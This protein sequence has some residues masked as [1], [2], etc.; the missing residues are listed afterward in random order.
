MGNFQIG[1]YICKKWEK[2]RG[3]LW[4]AES[5]GWWESQEGFRQDV[6]QWSQILDVPGNPEWIT[7]VIV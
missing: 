7:A 1:T 6:Q 5:L 3:E 2:L 4:H